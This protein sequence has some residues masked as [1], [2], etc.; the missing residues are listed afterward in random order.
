MPYPKDV[1]PDLAAQYEGRDC[2]TRSYNAGFR[3]GRQ[4]E[5][6]ECAKDLLAQEKHYREKGNADGASVCFAQ[7]IAIRARG[8]E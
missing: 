3:R 8:Q 1:S 6:E 5:R 4:L 7:A 2:C